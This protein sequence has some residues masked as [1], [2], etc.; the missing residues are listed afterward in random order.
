MFNKK[1]A[2]FGLDARIALAIFGALS[3][4]SGAALYGA[5]QDAKV[6]RMMTDAN[7]LGKAA[8]AYLL[9]T[10]SYIK[11]SVDYPGSSLHSNSLIT[12]T[13]SLDNW[14][15]PYIGFEMCQYCGSDY[16]A[17]PMFDEQIYIGYYKADDWV[18]YSDR[19]CGDSDRC[20]LFVVFDGV[21]PDSLVYALETK[22]DG[23]VSP[24]DT[25]LTGKLRYSRSA[26]NWIYY[27]IS[28]PYD[29]FKN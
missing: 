3:V 7:E 1:G 16:F 8:E 22:V 4:I 29:K 11:K 12:N 13:E 28:I 10:G 5:I 19:S 24:T 2:M 27:D 21:P 23:T 9:D 6:T 20:G 18:S 26:G 15:G 25:S 14:Q 17:Y